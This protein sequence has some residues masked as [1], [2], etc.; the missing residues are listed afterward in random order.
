[1]S[2]QEEQVPELDSEAQAFLSR[3]QL[4]GE[5]SAEAL[6]RARQRL[7]TAPAPSAKP[8][9]VVRL[10]PRR[11]PFVPPEVLAAAA[12]V[13]LLLGAQ[14]LYLVMRTPVLETENQPAP[15]MPDAE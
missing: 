11:R 3:H 13:I 5:P 10:A 12:V 2:D 1:M 6:E 8:A 9:S 14:G 4:T 7:T 15:N